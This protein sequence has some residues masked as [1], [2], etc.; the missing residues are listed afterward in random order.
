MACTRLPLSSL[1]WIQ[2]GHPLERKKVGGHPAIT[3]LEFAPG[4]SDPNWCLRAHVVYVLSGALTFELESGLVLLNEGECGV[5]DAGTAHRAQNHGA[6]TVVA[7]VASD[8]VA[9]GPQ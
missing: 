1:P 7:F 3:V 5:L 6:E 2:G 4:F 9:T 8:L